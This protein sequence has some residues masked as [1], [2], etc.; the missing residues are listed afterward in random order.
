M[1][2]IIQKAFCLIIICWANA[3]FGQLQFSSTPK[4]YHT[5]N[6]AIDRNKVQDDMLSLN[7]GSLFGLDGPSKRRGGI[8]ADNF[9]TGGKVS[10]S[11]YLYDATKTDGK[12]AKIY[13][14]FSDVASSGEDLI[15]KANTINLKNKFGA[16]VSLAES[17]IVKI[18]DSDGVI[19]LQNCNQTGADDYAAL[20]KGAAVGLAAGSSSFFACFFATGWFTFGASAIPCAFLGTGVG[21][22]SSYGAYYLSKPT[23]VVYDCLRDNGSIRPIIVEITGQNATVRKIKIPTL[24]TIEVDRIFIPTNSFSVIV[25]INGVDKPAITYPVT[26]PPTYDLTMGDSISVRVNTNV[27]V[28]PEI[29]GAT[30]VWPAQFAGDMTYQCEPDLQPNGYI[31]FIGLDSRVHT[32]MLRPYP[33]GFQQK[34]PDW[35]PKGS[36]LNGV[37]SYAWGWTADREMDA[38]K[39]KYTPSLIWPKCHLNPTRNPDGSY[40]LTTCKNMSGD[41]NNPIY[42]RQDQKE[43]L[44][45]QYLTYQNNWPGSL[46]QNYD[47]H[48]KYMKGFDDDELAYFNTQYPKVAEANPSIPNPCASPD[49]QNTGGITKLERLPW[50][51]MPEGENQINN[52]MT[53]FPERGYALNTVVEAYLKN[54]TNNPLVRYTGYEIQDNGVSWNA[55]D[56]AGANNTNPGLVSIK[57]GTDEI[58]FK[59]NVR[60]PLAQ[61]NGR[62]LGFYEALVGPSN[63]SYAETNVRYWLRGVSFKNDDEISKYTLVYSFMDRLGNISE[64]TLNVKDNIVAPMR[65]SHQTWTTWVNERDQTGT[66]SFFNFYNYFNSGKGFELERPAYSWI[67]AYYQRTPTS[68]KVPVAGKEL[69]PIFLM[70]CGIDSLNNQKFVE[71]RGQ[72]SR[73]FLEEYRQAS[74]SNST[75]NQFNNYSDPKTFGNIT[76][77]SQKYTR[78]YVISPNSKVTFTTIDG[79]P[80]SFDNEDEE[81]YL[82]N[83]S[84]AKR[85]RD[86]LLDGRYSIDETTGNHVPNNGLPNANK[87]YLKYYL[88][89]LNSDGSDAGNEYNLVTVSQTSG[90]I[91]PSIYRK[92]MTCT[93][94]DEGYYALKISYRNGSDL[95]HRIRVVN[96]DSQTKG[97]I[98]QRNLNDNEANWLG[99]SIQT[100][101]QKY[102]VYEIKDVQSSFKYKDGYRAKVSDDSKY[103]GK[104]NRWSKF[105]DYADEY[106]WTGTTVTNQETNMNTD[107]FVSTYLNHYNYN[108]R[109]K[110]FWKDW[111]LHYSSNWL[112]IKNANQEQGLPPYVPEASVKR[113]YDYQT[114]LDSYSNYIKTKLFNLNTYAN[115][116]SAPWQFVIPLLSYTDYY[117]IRARTNPSCIYDLDKVLGASGAFSGTPP[118]PTSPENIQAPDYSDDYKDQQEFFHDLKYGRKLIVFDTYNTFDLTTTLKVYQTKPGTSERTFVATKTALNNMRIAADEESPLE[119]VV[120]PNPPIDNTIVLR[121]SNKL[122]K[123]ANVQLLDMNGRVLFTQFYPII[124]KDKIEIPSNNLSS[125]EYI[126]KAEIDGKTLNKKVIIVK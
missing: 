110:W 71:G 50:K 35:N 109:E 30:R 67:T 119:I 118:N 20:H 84:M 78:E 73:I 51:T 68:R 66:D 21:V 86:Y 34:T 100:T 2:I 64:K 96:Y 60:S 54:K 10:L 24:P 91:N 38:N 122:N 85:V 103:N 23:K 79:D 17:D 114:G 102:K 33:S 3:T 57:V 70:F 125:G 25:S 27:N 9:G 62:T 49:C 14:C 58:S 112:G 87:A 120:A 4:T 90:I 32:L 75:E 108:I 11:V 42:Q 83:R 22:T 92:N 36:V 1:K 97:K 99:L 95:Y 126:V 106:V 81:W 123:E 77:Y 6:P 16:T 104:P 28:T 55:P 12:G 47:G 111:A 45:I 43:G 116:L 31:P 53:G 113:I 115:Q 19:T 26:T 98:Y 40:D 80:Y 101:K 48:A 18:L 41:A 7:T 56:G 107:I 72:G 52:S 69:T 88:K 46:F 76:K 29:H 15:E 124:G 117:G 37:Y 13:S 63:P 8:I 5:I 93:F 105:N 61:E 94:V 65:T 89:K 39:S 82:S 74:R 121:L 44:N 59:I